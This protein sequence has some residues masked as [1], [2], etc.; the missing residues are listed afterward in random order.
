MGLRNTVK[1]SARARPS[2]DSGKQSASTLS[3]TRAGFSGFVFGFSRVAFW[4]IRIMERV[5]A[6]GSRGL[7]RM[8]LCRLEQDVALFAKGQFYDAFGC[9]VLERQHHLLVGDNN[10]VD[11]QAAALDLAPG[12]AVGCDKPNCDVSVK[13]TVASFEFMPSDF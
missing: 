2:T 1:L 5:S 10:V 12:F 3:A 6:A 4:S 11:A 8:R 9:Q 13:D 7:G